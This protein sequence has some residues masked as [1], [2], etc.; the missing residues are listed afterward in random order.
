[1]E[2]PEKSLLHLTQ[3]EEQAQEILSD[4]EDIVALDKQRNHNREAIR[5]LHKQD[6]TSAWIAVGPLLVK[7]PIKKVSDTLNKDQVR[8]DVE[9]NRLRSDLKVKVNKLRDLEHASPVPGLMLNPMSQADMNAMGQ[10]LGR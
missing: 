6:K 3:I 10:V 5:A 1:M 7:M 2:N 9:V 8:L 4:R